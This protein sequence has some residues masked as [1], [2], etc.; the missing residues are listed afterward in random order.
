METH[1]KDVAIIQVKDDGAG[2]RSQQCEW[3]L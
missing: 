3:D 2:L 1:K